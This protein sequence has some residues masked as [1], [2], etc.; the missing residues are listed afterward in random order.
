MDY[1]AMNKAQK[2]VKMVDLMAR[3]GG[4]TA[5]DLQ[6]RFD[7]DAR[8]L[9]RYL[10]DLRDLDLPILDDG[11][12]DERIIT[13]D[14]KWRRTGVQLTL[15]EVLSLH[16]S[17]KLFTFLE[18]TAFTSGVDGAIERLE[19]AISRGHADTAR[20]LDTRFLAV[21]EPAKDYRGQASEALDELVDAIVYNHVLEARYR[22]ASGVESKYILHPYT[23]ATFRQ[24]LYLFALDVDAAQVKTF[25]VERFVD[26]VRRR[27]DHFQMPHGWRPEA[28]IAHAFGIIGGPPVHVA[29]AFRD[30]V[31]GYIKERVWHPTQ[32]YRTLADGRLELRMHVACTVELETWILGFGSAAQVLE[33][34]ALVDR[35]RSALRDAAAQYGD[36]T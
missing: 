5:A 9:R 3:V 33:P 36:A 17:R 30:A 31:A 6:R 11:R 22:K 7:L 2:M 25:A 26:L 8:T 4:V 12:G 21:P 16:F 29:I 1:E 18:G 35:I 19:P 14:A 24:G 34:A 13:I 27:R 10:S 20:Q 28:Q 15:G 32:V 23:L